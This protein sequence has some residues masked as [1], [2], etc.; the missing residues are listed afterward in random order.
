MEKYFFAK[1]LKKTEFEEGRKQLEK[2]DQ[3]LFLVKCIQIGILICFIGFLAI[4]IGT[5]S[6]IQ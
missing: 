2:G 3:Y 6:L 1:A 5:Y 4:S